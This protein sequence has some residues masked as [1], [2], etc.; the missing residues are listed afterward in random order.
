MF[1][2]M[3]TCANSQMEWSLSY[4]VLP[5]SPEFL[6][7]SEPT[8]E[9]VAKLKAYCASNSKLFAENLLTSD[10]VHESFFSCRA[11]RGDIVKC[12]SLAPAEW[13]ALIGDAAHA[14]AP[15]TGEGINS[16]LESAS[17]LANVIIRGG[18]CKDFD[19]ERRE[20]AHAAYAIACRNRRIVAGTP[21]QKCTNTFGSIVLGICKKRG[22]V[23]GT[24]QD[25]MLG[26]KSANGV[27]RYSDLIRMDRRQRCCL[28][29]CG[30]S[31]F[32]LCCCCCG[33]C[34]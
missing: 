3:A 21:Q 8:P 23:T 28:D 30:M 6:S 13:V 17:I 19:N 29:P 18:S 9:N 11:F 12:S 22:C 14:V 5:H 7:S 26:R 31:C 15:F 4:S 24:M 33:K 27:W 1:L 32:F 25:Y 34:R 2:A 16:A 10:Q 20:D